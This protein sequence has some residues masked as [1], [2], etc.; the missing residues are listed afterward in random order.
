M[1]IMKKGEGRPE[2]SKF[3]LI[4][5]MGESSEL[6][7]YCCIFRWELLRPPWVTQG[8]APLSCMEGASLWQF[9]ENRQ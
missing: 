6:L 5:W 1:L 7:V 2:I 3:I 8:K 4:P 9:V